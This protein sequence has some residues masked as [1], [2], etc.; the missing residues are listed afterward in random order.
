MNRA[1]RV[2]DRTVRI[3]R[4]PVWLCW[5]ELVWCGDRTVL[6][7]FA[8]GGGAGAGELRPCKPRRRMVETVGRVWG[9]E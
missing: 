2:C 3:E 8:F 5:Y 6:V 7:S 9:R 4:E 1:T